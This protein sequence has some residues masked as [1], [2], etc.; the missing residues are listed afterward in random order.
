MAQP[1]P[2]S[3][4]CIRSDETALD[5]DHLRCILEQFNVGLPRD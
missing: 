1:L 4:F 2:A 5:Y 3:R